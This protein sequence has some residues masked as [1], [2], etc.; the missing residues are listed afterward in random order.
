MYRRAFFLG[1]SFDRKALNYVNVR[2]D[3]KGRVL[4]LARA[5][6][7]NARTSRRRKIVVV[8]NRPGGLGGCLASRGIA[9][10]PASIAISSRAR[11][12]VRPGLGCV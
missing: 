7:H 4:L 12:K 1:S 10:S 3:S 2:Q 8:A 5:R 11:K 6:K 9:L